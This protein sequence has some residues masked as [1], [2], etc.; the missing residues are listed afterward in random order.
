MLTATFSVLAAIAGLVVIS[1]CFKLILD[2]DG[3]L[4][5]SNVSVYD[6]T[7]DEQRTTSLTPTNISPASDA[8]RTNENLDAINKRVAVIAF[9]V[10]ISAV[11]LGLAG[12]CTSKIKRCLCTCTF[13]FASMLMVAVYG[14]ASFVLLSM[15]YVTDA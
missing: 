14:L 6:K 9:S 3:I 10:G 11:V 13:G 15:Y 2:I 5:D 7:S 12:I 1:F 8:K 4:G